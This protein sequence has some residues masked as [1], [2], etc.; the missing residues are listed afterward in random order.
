MPVVSYRSATGLEVRGK[1]IPYPKRVD[2]PESWVREIRKVIPD[3]PDPGKTDWYVTTFDPSREIVLIEM[4]NSIGQRCRMAILRESGLQE[5][6][7][8]E[9]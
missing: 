6:T 3:V 8:T 9:G 1:R 2:R 4:L 7:G 5:R